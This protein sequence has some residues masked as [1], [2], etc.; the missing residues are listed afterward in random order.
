MANDD[1]THPDNW[2]SDTLPLVAVQSFAKADV[3]VDDIK[4]TLKEHEIQTLADLRDDRSFCVTDFLLE[5][6]WVYFIN[7]LSKACERIRK[8]VEEVLGGDHVLENDCL[9]QTCFDL[10]APDAVSVVPDGSQALDNGLRQ[11]QFT[12]V[13]GS[14][15]SGK[16]MFPL[17]CLP[18]LLFEDDTSYFGV[19]FQA[20]EALRTPWSIPKPCPVLPSYKM[21]GLRSFKSH[22]PFNHQRFKEN[23]CVPT[24]IANG[25]VAMMNLS[26]CMPLL[27]PNPLWHMSILILPFYNPWILSLMH[28]R[29][30]PRFH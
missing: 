12:L 7:A 5:N 4:K 15:G 2:Y 13:L 23:T 19:H 29:H 6:K 22:P 11:K 10:Y 26:N 1:P 14:S 27:Y 17:R 16:T 8:T 20:T 21:W 25:V 3:S 30:G 18:T 28:K 9:P 24:Y